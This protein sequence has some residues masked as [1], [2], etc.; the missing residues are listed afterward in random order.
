M[1]NTF[2]VLHVNIY[3]KN[4]FFAFSLCVCVCLSYPGDLTE[5]LLHQLCVEPQGLLLV[6]KIGSQRKV[7]KTNVATHC[8][9]ARLYCQVEFRKY[10]SNNLQSRKNE[11]NAQLPKKI[12]IS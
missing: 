3:I 6:T 8:S 7:N 4:V 11:A 10:L 1:V 12:A 2:K 5:P 9:I